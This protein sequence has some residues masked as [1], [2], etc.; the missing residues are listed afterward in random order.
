MSG[1]EILWAFI[2]AL[3]VTAAGIAVVGVQNFLKKRVKVHGPQ[4]EQ[5]DKHESKIGKLELLVLVLVSNQ[6]PILVA[7]LGMLEAHKQDMNGGFERAYQ[8]IQDALDKFDRALL[9]AL[10]GCNKSAGQ[11]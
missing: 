7:L 11:E 10:S 6:K 9:D 1:K 3:I 5:I 8:G 4:S 2:G